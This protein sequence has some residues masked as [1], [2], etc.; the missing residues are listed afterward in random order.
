MS[1]SSGASPQPDVKGRPGPDVVGSSVL[2]G[3]RVVDVSTGPVGGMATMVLADFGADV[4]KVEPPGGDRFRSVPAAPLWLRGKRSFTA[5]LSAAGGIADLHSLVSTADVLVVAGP[6]SRARRWGVDA[7]QATVLAPELVHCSIT[8]WGPVG[9]LAEVPGYEGAVAARSGRMMAFQRQLHRGG[10]V[11]AAVPVAGHAA[12]HGAVQGILAA[13][14]ARLRGGG[15]Q[16]VETSLLQGLLPYDL[17]ELLVVEMA[18]RN[19]VAI[20]DISAA[21]GDLPTLNYHP[22]HTKD[23]RW[24]QCGN[25]LEHLLYAFLAATDLLGEMVA[26][27]RFAGSPATWDLEAVEAARDMILLRL[28]ERTAD[29]WMAIFRADGNVAA[30]PYI[31]TVEALNHPDI[32]DNGDVITLEDPAVGRVRTI[33]PIATLTRTPAGVKRCAPR[34]GEHTEEIRAELR[35]GRATTGRAGDPIRDAG[36]PRSPLE[37]ITVVEFASVIAAPLST[38]MLADLGAR[39]IKVETIGGDPYRHLVVGGTPGAKT[40]AGKSSICLDLKTPEGLRIAQAL[41][42]QADVVVHNARP[43][44]AERLGLGEDEL[45]SQNPLLIWVSLTGY[46]RGSR[47][48]YRPATHPCAG[49]ATGGALFQAGSALQEPCAGLADVREISRQLIRANESSPDP[50]TAVVAAGSVLMALLA[51]ERFG[52]GQAVHI[53]MLA[54]NMYANADDALD[55]ASKRARPACDPGLHGFSAGYRLY[56]CADGWLFLAISSDE[57]WRQCAE[58]LALTSVLDNPRFSTPQ[59]RAAN[60]ALLIEVLAGVFASRSAAEWEQR[61]VDAGLAGVRADSATPGPYFAHDPQMLANDFTPE[62]T[63]ARF[64]THRRWGPLVRVNGGLESYGPGVVAGQQTDDLLAELGYLQDE[65]DALRA[66]GVV[67]SEPALFEW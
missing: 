63:H 29:E 20:P 48:A 40:T 46:G 28:E 14:L 3:I 39:V 36:G 32:V 43:G 1:I 42:R 24:I 35:V 52:I 45:R 10:P 31:T 16:R 51:R 44:V 59:A 19:H 33:G 37:G 47:S 7:E 58:I 38:A 65:I 8:G 56:R 50:N 54:A 23:G 64:G 60:D 15:A 13:L 61:F 49:A 62:C 26:D 6:P 9:P 55:Y 27:P 21:G 25:L 5:D 41:C 2:E 67:G 18:E 57:E 34:P 4:I 17:T 22:V 30:E 53:N 66:V 11:F 12:A